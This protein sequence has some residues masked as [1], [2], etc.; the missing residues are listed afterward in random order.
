MD[1]NPLNYHSFFLMYFFYCGTQFVFKHDW[2]MVYRNNNKRGRTG[3][4]FRNIEG[5]KESQKLWACEASY[6]VLNQP[7]SSLQN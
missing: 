4:F 5:N 6:V 1:Q 2:G 3:I 7:K